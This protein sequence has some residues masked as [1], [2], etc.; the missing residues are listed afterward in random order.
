MRKS[1]LYLFFILF[2]HASF[3][4]IIPD[5]MR[6]DWSGAG[7]GGCLPNPS[8]V[9]NVL[10]FGGSGDSITNNLTAIN[11]ALDSLHGQPGVIWFPAGIYSVSSTISIPSGAILRGAGAD[12]TKLKM[13]HAGYGFSFA[14]TASGSFVNILG[15][16]QKGS[17]RI[18]TV[19]G[20]GLVQGDYAEILE[21]NGAW[22]TVPIS[23]ATDVVGQVVKITEVHG[24]TLILQKPLRLNL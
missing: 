3:G 15:G 16:Y 12:S 6:V 1:I 11:A 17:N 24:D 9:L 20:H 4:Q 18:H 5:S 14:G 2:F 19:T 8:L 10:N 13:K 21:T 23:W 22:N 7:Y